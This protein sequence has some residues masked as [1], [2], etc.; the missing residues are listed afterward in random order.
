MEAPKVGGG[1]MFRRIGDEKGGSM[2]WT[3]DLKVV[4]INI[5]AFVDLENS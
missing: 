3:L 5:S 1:G 2:S 4:A